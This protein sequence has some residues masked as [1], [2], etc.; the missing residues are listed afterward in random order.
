MP[1]LARFYGIRITM[2][3]DAHPPARFHAEYGSDAAMVLVSNGEVYR[4]CLPGRAGRLVKE[5]ALLHR[6]ELDENWLQAHSGSPMLRIAP[7]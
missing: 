4:G 1:E 6:D 5:W 7:L 3:I 2:N